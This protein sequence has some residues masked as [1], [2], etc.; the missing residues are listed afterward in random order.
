ME[1]AASEAEWDDL[2]WH[3]DTIYGL[4]LDVGDPAVADWRSDLVLDIDHI[5]AWLCGVAG[6]GA[7]FQVAP[8]TLTF[9]NVTDLRIAVDLGDSGHRVALRPLSVDSITRERIEHQQICLDRPYYA[10]RVTLNNPPGGLLTFGA[11]GF[12]L[13]L[14][15]DPVLLDEQRIPAANRR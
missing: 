4:R 2:S 15:A 3:D 13:V 10:W 8:A 7:R 1:R 9:H 14:S 5:V 6:D 12:S 11:S